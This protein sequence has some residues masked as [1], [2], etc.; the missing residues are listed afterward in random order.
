MKR[1]YVLGVALA[2]V[3]LSVAPSAGW[4]IASGQEEEAAQLGAI[5]GLV[6]QDEDGDGEVGPEEFGLAAV[7]VRLRGEDVDE[8]TLTD[9]SGLY[10][11]DDLAPGEYD[12]MVEPGMTWSVI[13]K[14]MY[15]GLE[16]EDELLT[17]LDF[18]LQSVE[19]PEAELEALPSEEEEVAE[20]ADE[21][22]AAVE[23]E[24]EEIVTETPVPE[25]ADALE[26]VVELISE[27]EEEE[28]ELAEA[29]DTEE[30]AEAEEADE[31]VAEEA[32]VAETE[33]EAAEAEEAE[34]AET[35]EEAAEAEE[36]E[37]VT[38]VTVEEAEP[39]EPE[40]VAEPVY[41]E[42]PPTGVADIG[43]SSLLALA[44]LGLGVLGGAGLAYER[45][46]RS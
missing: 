45:R 28:E 24:A 18:A 37:A 46:R 5:E 40:V 7:P 38:V 33:E 44:T 19:A 20:V 14:S 39:A 3:L 43:Q 35:E 30:L 21:S 22:E 29:A 25:L 42:M 13:G 4:S 31:P 16:I 15:E 27:P 1:C 17:G 26:G 6:F 34:V 36:A 41:A 8:T 2:A 11:F 12:L 10:R 9:D 32:E 23:E